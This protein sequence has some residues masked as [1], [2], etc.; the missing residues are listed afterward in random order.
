ME[1]G[2]GPNEGCSAKGKKLLLGHSVETVTKLGVA[3]RGTGLRSQHEY[4]S[5]SYL[6]HS[7]RIWGPPYPKGMSGPI[8]EVKRMVVKTDYSPSF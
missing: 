7:D 8:P 4:S 6:L 2:Q 1:V 5:Y 3:N